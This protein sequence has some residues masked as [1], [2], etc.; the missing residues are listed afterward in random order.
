MIAAEQ[1]LH[2]RV[3]ALVWIGIPVMLG[4]VGCTTQPSSNGSVRLTPTMDML[5]YCDSPGMENHSRTCK[6]MVDSLTQRPR[7]F[8]DNDAVRDYLRVDGDAAM[9]IEQSIQASAEA[10]M[11]NYEATRS[12]QYDDHLTAE[13]TRIAKALATQAVLD[14][15]YYAQYEQP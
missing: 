10:S 9:R 7:E 4:I 5:A 1:S 15:T 13:D 12:A 11:L 2:R 8:A 6:Y 14:A 3:S